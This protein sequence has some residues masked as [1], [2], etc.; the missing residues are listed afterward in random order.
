VQVALLLK[1]SGFNMKQTILT[2]VKASSALMVG[3]F[4]YGQACVQTADAVA[5]RFAP[6]GGTVSSEFGWRVDPFTKGKRFHSGLDIAAP[7]GTPVFNPEPGS[8]VYAGEYA[9]YGNVVV[10]KHDRK[11][12]YTLYGHNSKLLVAR[13]QRV[14]PG[15]PVAL[16][17]STGRST[18]P[19]LHFE[20]HFNNKYMNPVDYLVFL[21]QELISKG[22]ANPT[23][24]EAQSVPTPLPPAM[25]GPL[26]ENLFF[27]P[28]EF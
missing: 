25:G 3:V 2:L 8:V 1:E 15:Q 7:V 21:Q 19:H 16:V 24:E 13:G 26:P 28:I 11:G 17:G 27:G 14:E 20:V 4:L 23:V 10:V 9:G 22:L 6:A 5:L 18:G 12:L